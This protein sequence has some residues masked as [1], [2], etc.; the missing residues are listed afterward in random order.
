MTIDLTEKLN[1]ADK[2]QIKIKD[3][4][5][6]INDDTKSMLEL[7]DILEKNSE[8]AMIRQAPGIIFDKT[9]LAKL[10]KLNLN[11]SDYMTVIKAAISLM[12]GGDDDEDSG[13]DI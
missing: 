7:M 2:P 8:V 9:S 10:D 1:F 5:L 4:K 3:T 13:S 12:K 6:T 11:F